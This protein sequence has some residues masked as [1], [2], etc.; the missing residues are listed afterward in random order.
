MQGFLVTTCDSFERVMDSLTNVGV[1]VN[2]ESKDGNF[3]IL[4]AP[5]DYQI[6]TFGAYKFARSLLVNTVK[7]R[8]S[9]VFIVSDLG[10]FLLT[11]RTT[12]MY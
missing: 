1:S 12:S 8:K 10:S 6:G 9:T 2:N 4:D 5:K 11:E 7:D 3:I